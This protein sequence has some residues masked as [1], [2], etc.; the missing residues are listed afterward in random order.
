MRLILCVP[1]VLSIA[2]V[3]FAQDAGRGGPPAAPRAMTLAI[4]GFPEGS[5]IP[6][7]FS[8]AVQGVAPSEGTSPGDE[9]G[10]RARWHA[11]LPPHARLGS[12][13]QQDY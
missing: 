7:E 10:Q 2:I 4:P 3:P 11:E 1:A 12:R 6:V 5:Q 9:L 8:Q 13:P